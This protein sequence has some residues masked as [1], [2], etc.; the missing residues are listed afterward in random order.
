MI[1]KNF[2]FLYLKINFLKSF[3]KKGRYQSSKVNVISVDKRIVV[4]VETRQY[5]E[6]WF[7]TNPHKRI[8]KY[9][10]NEFTYF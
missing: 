7:R 3:L 6:S 4:K 9:K 8:P 2:N 1:Q 10:I 5:L